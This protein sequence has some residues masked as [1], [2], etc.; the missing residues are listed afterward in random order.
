MSTSTGTT[1]ENRAT[2]ALV[3]ADKQEKQ[4]HGDDTFNS[5]PPSGRRKTVVQLPGALACQVPAFL[6]P[7][8]AKA[9]RGEKLALETEVNSSNT[10]TKSIES[11]DN[12]VVA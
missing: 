7:R 9:V 1:Q 11:S 12:R 10:T 3:L 5:P 6:F 4:R 8:K 2:D